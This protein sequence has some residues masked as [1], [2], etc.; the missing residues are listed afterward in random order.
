MELSDLIRTEEILVRGRVHGELL[1]AVPIVL[2]AKVTNFNVFLLEF[3]FLNER[4]FF[5]A[6]SVI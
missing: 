1:F 4:S 6:N 5:A 3:V 2:F